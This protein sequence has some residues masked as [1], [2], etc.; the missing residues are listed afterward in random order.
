MRDDKNV[1][2][3]KK[4]SRA[5]FWKAEGNV[6]VF[7]FSI[8]AML[9]NQGENETC[10]VPDENFDGNIGQHLVASWLP[11][12]FWNKLIQE[13]VLFCEV[14]ILQKLAHF[15]NYN[16]MYNHKLLF[17]SNTSNR[18]SNLFFFPKG[19]KL[20]PLKS[21]TIFSLTRHT[22]MQDTPHSDNLRFW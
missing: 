2:W 11:T 13:Y 12:C 14:D 9:C 21:N 7:M 22:R 8:Q 18:A 19:A 16:H 15:Y 17:D 10:L 6:Q 20:F 4:K 5:K 1:I 3:W